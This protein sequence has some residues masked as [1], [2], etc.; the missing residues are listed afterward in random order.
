LNGENEM[1][2]EDLTLKQ[3]KDLQNIFDNKKSEICIGSIMIGKYCIARGGGSGVHV[4][5]VTAVSG[6]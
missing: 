4:G 3:I 2:I 6:K 1:D 5:I